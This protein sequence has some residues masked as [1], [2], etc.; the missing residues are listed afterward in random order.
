MK[1]SL[2][3]KVPVY[4]VLLFIII[5]CPFALLYNYV[6]SLT[7]EE[8]K[9]RKVNSCTKWQDLEFTGRLTQIKKGNRT[10]RHIFI[11]DKSY[12]IDDYYFKTDPSNYFG[13]G[14]SIYKEKGGKQ[15]FLYSNRYGEK[16][17][18]SIHCD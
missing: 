10:T 6:F 13:I 2:L 3:P 1:I 12:H 14:D 17:I 4:I 7:D 15:M 5:L 18:E 9:E 11:K 8:I 16:I